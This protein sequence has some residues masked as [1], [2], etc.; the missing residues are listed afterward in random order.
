MKHLLQFHVAMSLVL[1]VLVFTFHSREAAGSFLCGA[2]V[3]FVNLVLLV[4][5][6]PRILAKKQVALSIGIIVIKFAILGWIL[7]EVV[8]QNL[9]QV[10]W[11]AT[12]LATITI[13]VLSAALFISQ[14]SSDNEMVDQQVLGPQ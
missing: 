9:L 5:V 11:F 8:S 2:T 13:T 3:S 12:G 4:V 14:D 7:Y 1:S 10:G 6:W